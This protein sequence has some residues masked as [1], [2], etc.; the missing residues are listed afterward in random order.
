MTPEERN[1]HVTCSGGDV[2]D[3]V[4]NSPSGNLIRDDH[5]KSVGSGDSEVTITGGRQEQS[6]FGEEKGWL[7]KLAR[8]CATQLSPDHPCVEYLKSHGFDLGTTVDLNRFTGNPSVLG[9]KRWYISVTVRGRTGEFLVDTGA[10]HSLISK[11]FY[12]LVSEEHDKFGKNVN[13]LTADGSS[14]QTFGRTFLTIGITGREYILSPTIADISDDGILGLDFAALFEAVL[15]PKKGSM[16]IKHPYE[17][18]VK[19]VLRQISS[20]ASVHQTVKVLPGTT[21][22]VLC[23]SSVH[24][25]DKIGVFEPDLGRLSDLGL[26]SVD[27]LI[28]NSSYTVIP[29][30]NRNMKTVYLKKGT[31]VGD[32]QLTN[33]VEDCDLK[34]ANDQKTSGELH[35]DLQKLVDDSNLDNQDQRDQMSNMLMKY[36]QAFGLDGEP[37]GRTDKVL[38]QIDTGEA[39]PFKIPYRRLPLKKKQE[40]ER[41]IQSQL[42]ENIIVPSTSPWSSPIQMVTKLSLIHI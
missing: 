27:T 41:C 1:C 3:T 9:G 13:A 36:V 40:A 39:M 4:V 2:K 12:S 20:V 31:A 24:F 26:E 28:S 38:H 18:K 8:V 34:I 21:C 42:S 19:C 29:I 22:D 11:K 10:S 16:F 30:T 23:V 6:C 14:M 25:R 37:T 33:V 35:K 32:I 17:Q 5:S 7:G 15:D